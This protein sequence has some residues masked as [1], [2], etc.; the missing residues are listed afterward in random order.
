M[1]KVENCCW[2]SPAGRGLQSS[3]KCISGEDDGLVGWA[4]ARSAE[5]TLSVSDL[6]ID[7]VG[8]ALARRAT[9]DK[10]LSPRYETYKLT[11]WTG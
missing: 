9:A 5:P 7:T 3:V 6:L 8:T 4:K 1:M 10:S 11:F 2:P